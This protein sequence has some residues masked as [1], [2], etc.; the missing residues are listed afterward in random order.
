MLKCYYS[1]SALTRLLRAVSTRAA[2][3]TPMH[4]SREHMLGPH[5]AGR[6]AGRDRG[7]DEHSLLESR[8]AVAY[9][10]RL[11]LPEGGVPVR[12]KSSG[13]GQLVA[14]KLR[15]HPSGHSSVLAFGVS[16]GRPTRAVTQSSS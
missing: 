4:C 13:N 9:Q 10:D 14:T 6:Y 11:G 8:G 3:D 12:V 5:R 1:T 7:R 2:S 16:S 15:V